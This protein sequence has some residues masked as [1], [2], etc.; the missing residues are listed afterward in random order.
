MRGQHVGVDV[1]EHAVGV[2]SNAG[3]HRDVTD[4]GEVAE[5]RCFG[6][7][8]FADESQVGHFARHRL[9]RCR[10]PRQPDT[11]VSSRETHCTSAG[12]ANRRDKR[13]VRPARE[14]RDDGVERC[15]I[16]DA[17]A[18]D[19]ARRFALRAQLGVDRA[20]AAMHDNDWRRGSHADDR[21]RRR[22][23]SRCVFKQFAAEFEDRCH[24]S[25][26][27]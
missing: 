12:R 7:F 21:L 3:D 10:A 14:H 13:S 8:R 11:S 25:V 22:A 16:G 19:E 2:H 27:C 24:L 5:Q 18:V 23:D 1:E 6:R 9:E 4:G 26:R 20:A 15:L 17:Q